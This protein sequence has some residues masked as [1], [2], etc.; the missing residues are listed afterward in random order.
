MPKKNEF[1]SY[2][3]LQ[4][5]I[6]NRRTR[7]EVFRKKLFLKVSQNLR[8]KNLRQSLFLIKLQTEPCNF[9][10]KEALT[11]VFLCQCFEMFKNT[12]LMEHL[13]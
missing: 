13:R 6:I 10:K 11:Q 12:F 3:V 8:K 1:C 4:R 9:I 2:S 5:E 7:P